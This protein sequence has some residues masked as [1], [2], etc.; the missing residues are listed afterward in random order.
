MKHRNQSLK[1]YNLAILMVFAAVLFLST[2]ASY[3]AGAQAQTYK[4]Q[5]V[6]VPGTA[7][8][9]PFTAAVKVNDAETEFA[10]YLSFMGRSMTIPGTIV[11]GAY[12][13]AA[14]GSP[15]SAMIT[16]R[17]GSITGQLTKTWIPVT[18]EPGKMCKVTF[19]SNYDK[20]ADTV[21]NVPSADIIIGPTLN[22]FGYYFKGY[23]FDQAATRPLK[24][25]AAAKG[26]VTLYAGWEKWGDETLKYMNTYSSLM[27]KGE[28]IMERP[29]AYE[30]ESFTKFYELAFGL[31]LKIEAAGNL[32]NKDDAPMLEYAMKTMN[33]VVRTAD[34]EKYSW[35][36]WGD[37]MPMAA[38]AD[39]YE[40][41]GC[42]DNEKWR[43]FLVPYM[44][45]DQ[46]KVKANIIVVAGGGYFLRS[47]IE[48]AYSTAKVMNDL[49][50][51]CFVLQRRVSPYPSIDS[52]LDL[53]RAVRYLNYHAKEY[54]IAKIENLVTSGF[55]GGGGTITNA[56][57]T[58]YGAVSPGTVYPNYVDDEID[59]LNSD[60]DAM[61]VIYSSGDLTDCKNPNYPAVFL[62]YG[63]LDSLVN[64]AND[65]YKQL[66]EKGI[67]AE[68]H[69]FAGAPHG[70]GAGTGIPD[71]TGVNPLGFAN[72]IAAA[73]PDYEGTKKPYLLAYTGAQQWTKL[74][75]TFLDQVFK[76]KP[77]SY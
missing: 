74:A 12:K 45:K 24:A 4:Y 43:P 41:F 67:F 58:L 64:G 61:L 76:Y 21:M 68:V 25:D 44:L 5:I 60:V 18:A 73:K 70:F 14:D 55:S 38:D 34:P 9:Q 57:K 29:K 23:F 30:F 49:G 71:Y 62:A 26:D 6:N 59:K 35:Y 7:G 11:N 72:S 50:Y 69:G 31:F 10:I 56:A 66:K 51:N 53:Q 40:F 13:A 75:D 32:A 22:R 63:T 27:E 15:M 36:I 77:V 52:S 19:K 39:K 2:T 8:S 17:I 1:L 37:K 48:E 47:N 20:Q 46:S 54:G 3:A 65:Y 28:Y 16:S 42:L 33:E